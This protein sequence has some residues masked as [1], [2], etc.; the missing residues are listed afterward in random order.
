MAGGRL[1][2]PDKT[3]V[4][5]SFPST[6]VP[7]SRISSNSGLA[8]KGR[9]PL[10][11]DTIETRPD[12]GTSRHKNTAFE[13]EFYAHTDATYFA[14]LLRSKNFFKTK[15]KVWFAPRGRL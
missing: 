8:E 9:E 5:I 14:M 15:L 2:P 3:S 4:D 7:L 1:S 11:K 6:M 13:K 12:L 10:E